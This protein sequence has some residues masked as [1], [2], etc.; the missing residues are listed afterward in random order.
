ML[1]GARSPEQNYFFVGRFLRFVPA[2]SFSCFL[3]IESAI[4]LDA[5]LR[6]DFGRSPRL[7]DNAAP[8]AI[9]CF[10]DFAG[11][12][13]IRAKPAERSPFRDPGQRTAIRRGR[14][15]RSFLGMKSCIRVRRVHVDYA[16][17]DGLP[18]PMMWAVS[19]APGLAQ[20]GYERRVREVFRKKFPEWNLRCCAAA[21]EDT[22]LPED[23][24]APIDDAPGIWLASGKVVDSV[25]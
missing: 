3:V 4:C 8:A 21:H 5:P 12:Q 10:L 19:A 18:K 15:K 13:D 9:C 24:L 16:G 11:M 22:T 14:A 2:K 23:T 20:N 17:A 1:R 6:L 7:A 25:E